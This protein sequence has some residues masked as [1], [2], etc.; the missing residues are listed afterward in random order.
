[1]TVDR[2]GYLPS[3]NKRYS[4]P[5]TGEHSVD[6][7]GNRTKRI[8]NDRTGIRAA[9]N[10]KPYLLQSYQRDTGEFL[11]DLSAPI[12]INGRHWGGLRIGYFDK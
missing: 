1:M 2:N 4:K 10:K 5:L 3:H 7:V 6:L 11:K 12:I 9:R 8:F